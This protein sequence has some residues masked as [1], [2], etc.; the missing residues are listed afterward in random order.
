MPPTAP[1]PPPA[2]SSSVASYPGYQGGYSHPGYGLGRYGPNGIPQRPPPLG[3]PQA[4]QGQQEQQHTS[5]QGRAQGYAQAPGNHN[6]QPPPPFRHNSWS[7]SH[8]DNQVSSQCQSPAAGTMIPAYNH[9]QEV[10]RSRSRHR[11]EEYCYDRRSQ[12]QSAQAPPVEEVVMPVMLCHTCSH[13]GKMRSAGF[14]R[15]NPVIPG[16]PLVSTPCRRCKKKLEGS[17]R[18]SSRY[19]RIRKCHAD[20]PCDWPRKPFQVH[21]D[22]DENRGRRRTRNE[23]YVDRYSPS[24]PRVVRQE[25]SQ[26]HLGLRT[27]QR[28]P[29]REQKART[30]SSTP[31]FSRHTSSVW[32]PPDVVRLET[33]YKD[34]AYILPPEPLPSRATRSDEVWPPPDIVRTQPYIRVERRPLR[35]QSSRIIEFSPSPPPARPRSAGTVYRDE[36][37]ECRVRS[38]S[39]PPSRVN[40]R[41][42]QRNE[43]V[44][45]RIMSEN[46]SYRTV[47]RERRRSYHTSDETSSNAESM[48]RQRPK[49]PYC[50]VPKHG[51]SERRYHQ[52]SS[53]RESEESMH[54][55]VG[56]PRVHFGTDRKSEVSDPEPRG[57]TRYVKEDVSRGKTFGQYH[58]YTRQPESRKGEDFE[59]VRSRHC[60]V[61]QEKDYEDEVRMDKQRR[62]S[63]SPS[64]NLLTREYEEVRVR[65]ISPLPIGRSTQPP[66][67]PPPP[68]SHSSTSSKPPPPLYRHVSSTNSRSLRSSITS[69][70]PTRSRHEDDHTDSD[71]ARSGDV[72]V[73]RSWKGI[74]EQGRPTTFVEETRMLAEGSEGGSSAVREYRDLERGE[75]RRRRSVASRVWRDV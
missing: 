72:T 63:P 61:S 41:K 19:T 29:T 40:S 7:Y 39:I 22:H 49:S 71:S 35:R 74:D 17:Y 32:P 69:P 8:Q 36:S 43:G 10:V 30:S 58:D 47:A 4:Q 66:P 28:S 33:S 42:I 52:R 16:E 6:T 53:V 70:P 44:D 1:T 48:P 23:V 64:P 57:R 20:E 73:V 55:E 2:V 25:S 62:I 26:A 65:H 13:C 24:R 60:S 14:H 27:L 9:A 45:A 11:R 51:G 59:K 68:P 18:S 15:S 50:S 38:P 31:P 56:G 67:P 12:F 5:M 3:D 54:V 75:R 46:L 34:K 37:P 21:I